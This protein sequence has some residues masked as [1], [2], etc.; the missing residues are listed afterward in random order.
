MSFCSNLGDDFVKQNSEK[1]RKG[2][3][4]NI[5]KNTPIKPRVKERIPN[6][7]NINFIIL[8]L[9]KLCIY[10]TLKCLHFKVLYLYKNFCKRGLYEE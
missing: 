9:R 4:G 1:S 6:T 8:Y 3:V 7:K 5:G 10:Y 2:V